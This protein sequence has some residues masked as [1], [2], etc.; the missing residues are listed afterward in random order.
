ME[1]HP[2]P[3][4]ISSYQFRLVGDMT[5]KQF[6]QLAGGIVAGLIFYSTPLLPI[7]KWPLAF[8]SVILGVALAFLPLEER[9]LEKWILAFFRAIYSPTIFT[10]QKG[11][12]TEKYFQDESVANAEE[13]A[14]QEAAVEKYLSGTRV[15]PTPYQKLEDAER[16][17]LTTLTGLFSG[18]ANQV[19]G[20]VKATPQPANPAVTSQSSGEAKPKTLEIPQTQP[21]RVS[22]QAAP[23]LVV[24]EKLQEPGVQMA[25]VAPVIMG[26]QFISTRQAQFSVDAAPPTPATTPNVVVGQVVDDFRRILDSAIIEIRDSGGHPVRALRSNKV[27]HFITVTPL[28]NGRYEIITEKEGYQFTPVSFEAAG[29]IIP[30]IL[31]QGKLVTSVPNME[32]STNLMMQNNTKPI[33]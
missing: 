18:V 1:Q 20:A 9:P 25:Q 10:W 12:G 19:A 3:Q 7:I 32:S 24:E 5:L 30:P 14:Q 22:A 17:F 4:Q 27:G 8:I 15:I 6:F 23:K 31:V 16:G 26:N 29:E 21:I 11:T 2:I 13:T 28:E 33:I